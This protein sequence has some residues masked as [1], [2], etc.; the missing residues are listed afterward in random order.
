MGTW[1]NVE[2]RNRANR[3]RYARNRDKERARSHRYYL[4]HR[5]EIAQRV[6]ERR[7]KDLEKYRALSL[8]YYYEHKTEQRESHRRYRIAH[9][10]TYHAERRRMKQRKHDFIL[11]H[12]G[13][14]CSRCGFSDK[15]ILEIAHINVDPLRSKSG[16][17]KTLTSMSYAAIQKLLPTLTLLCPNCHALSHLDENGRIQ[18]HLTLFVKD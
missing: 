15:R 8:H 5:K 9:P 10:D 4:K 6:K 1:K 3:E 18:N 16:K 11:Q 13:D 12:L 14:K 2:A 17:R 7:L